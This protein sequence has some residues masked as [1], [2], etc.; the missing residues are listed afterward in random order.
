MW[1]MF[2]K[3]LAYS[4]FLAALLTPP[5]IPT[6]ASAMSLAQSLKRLEPTTRML[7][8]CDIEASKQISKKQKGVDRV[9]SEAASAPRTSGDQVIAKGAAFRA[10]GHWYAFQ[11]TC[12]VSSDHMKALSFTYKLGKEI[13]RSKWD[14]YELWQ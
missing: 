9:V 14:A 2:V 6:A 3:S 4:A 1:T 11:Y 8:V 7:Q 5:L 10:K 13:P 12:R